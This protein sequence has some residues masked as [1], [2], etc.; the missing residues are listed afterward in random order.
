MPD[1]S[2]YLSACKQMRGLTKSEVQRPWNTPCSDAMPV[3]HMQVDMCTV[4][5]MHAPMHASFHSSMHAHTL[6]SVSL[7]PNAPKHPLAHTHARRYA[8]VAHTFPQLPR[9]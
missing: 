3:T 8:R 6:A 1:L 5:W 9:W 2:M 4:A 7:Y